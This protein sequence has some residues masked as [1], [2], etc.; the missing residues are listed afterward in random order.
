MGQAKRWIGVVTLGFTVLA[1]VAGGV[2]TWFGYRLGQ[3]ALSKVRQPALNPVTPDDDP[4][5]FT[6]LAED[7]II[8]Q[9]Q[10]LMGV[11]HVR[12]NTPTPAPSD[13]NL[14]L[15]L[16]ALQEGGVYMALE[17]IDQEGDQAVLLLRIQNERAEA[18]QLQ[19]QF[20][21]RNDRGEIL[22]VE[23]EGL[24]VQ[25]APGNQATAVRVKVPIRLGKV[26]V[27]LTEVGQTIPFIELRDIALE[28]A[29]PAPTPNSTVN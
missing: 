8:R 9:V 15:P 22:D 2:A 7:A 11:S 28:P 24:P 3:E 27:G 17:R 25:L 6:L 12:P 1:L 5:P 23:V 10:A 26:R 20:I 21:V 14:R 18:V 13:P 16:L 4:K 19:R 29:Q